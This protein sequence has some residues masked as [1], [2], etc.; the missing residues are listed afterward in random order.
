M[1]PSDFGMNI[2]F[3]FYELH[4]E[5]SRFILDNTKHM[6][7][8]NAITIGII[9]F[10]TDGN[11]ITI[12]YRH[13]INYSKGWLN[14]LN[15]EYQHGRAHWSLVLALFLKSF[16]FPALPTKAKLVTKKHILNGH[17]IGL[18]NQ[19]TSAHREHHEISRAV[20]CTY[21]TKKSNQSTVCLSSFAPFCFG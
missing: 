20:R 21:I 6:S 1:S 10:L 9:V 14:Q 8:K 16:Q 19:I 5:H 4:Q 7:D 12:Y 13:Y 11:H 3:F 15:H 2:F 17:C 18:L